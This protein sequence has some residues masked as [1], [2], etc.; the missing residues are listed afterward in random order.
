MRDMS[1]FVDL[2][3]FPAPVFDHQEAGGLMDYAKTEQ[4]LGRKIRFSNKNLFGERQWCCCCRSG[5]PMSFDLLLSKHAP[6]RM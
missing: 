6:L 2:K 4:L 5:K 3:L 1:M